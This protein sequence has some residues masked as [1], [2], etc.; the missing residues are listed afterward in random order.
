MVSYR[1]VMLVPRAQLKVFSPLE[2]FPPRERERWRSYVEDGRGLTRRE[3][4]AAESGAA[5]TRL[6]TGRSRLGPDAAIVRRAGRRTLICPLQ[7][8]LRAAIALATFRRVVPP[9]AFDAFLP[10]RTSLGRLEQLSSSGRA[11]HVLDEPFAVPLHWFVAFSPSER[12]FTD[13]PEGAGPR[14]VYLTSVDQAQDRLERA[15][16][17]V[18]STVEDGEDVLAAL[19]DVAA[20][21]DAFDASSLLEL[22]YGGVAG[23]VPREVLREDRTCQE[24]WSAIDALASGDLLAAAAAYGVARSRWND[25]RGRQHAS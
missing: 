2:A 22:D 25:H 12:R 19:A 18:E 24:L 20:W 9:T 5:V 23:S 21:L 7:L 8:E 11:P 4:A 15:I 17:V 10:S 1:D 16:D 14:L 3:V 13:P 6:V